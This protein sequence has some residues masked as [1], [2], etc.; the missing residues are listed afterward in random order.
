VVRNHFFKRLCGVR[1]VLCKLSF[2]ELPHCVT[3]PFYSQLLG[4]FICVQPALGGFSL[5]RS[6]LLLVD[7]DKSV[8]SGLKGILEAH[9]FEVT[10]A[11]NVIEALTRIT[12]DSFDAVLTDLHMP[13]AGDGLIVVNAMRQANPKAVTIVLSGNPDMKKATAA[14][15]RQTDRIM[16]KSVKVGSIVQAIRQ[17][18][19]R[20]RRPRAAGPKLVRQLAV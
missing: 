4:L 13:G 18:L 14:I 5:A 9:E 2:C 17:G 3:L 15:L 10:T 7:D 20:K 12:S 19:A 8:L 11:S 16:K 6:R 1:G